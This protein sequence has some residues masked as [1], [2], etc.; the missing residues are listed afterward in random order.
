MCPNQE[1]SDIRKV[2]HYKRKLTKRT[3][4]ESILKTREDEVAENSLIK[5]TNSIKLNLFWGPQER[6]I[7]VKHTEASQI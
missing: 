6:E 5:L 7:A 3:K 1:Q 2:G 4:R